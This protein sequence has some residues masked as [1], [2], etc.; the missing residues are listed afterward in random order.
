VATR[1]LRLGDVE[2]PRIGLGTNRL[3]HT[4]DHVELISDAVADGIRHIDTA[5]LYAGGESETTI[6]DALSAGPADIVV[7][8]KGGYHPGDGRP[9]VLRA[10]IDE[11]L[12][13][14]RTDTIALYYLH[15]VDPTTPLEDSFGALK[16]CRDAGKIRHVGISEVS[17]DQVERA[18]R[19]VPITAV[20]NHYSLTERKHE[21]VVDHCA[22]AGIVFVP[23][24]PLRGVSS[25]DLERIAKQHG[26]TSPQIALAWLLRRSPMM[27]PIPGT[28]SRDH[29][30]ENLGALEVELDD[31]E[32]RALA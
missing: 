9:D 28:L 4:P 14:L 2:V 16:E 11:S 21:A 26:A 13:R 32:F 10:Q 22:Q 3:S 29:V 23:Y 19:V 31:E 1:S 20:Q 5:H 30:R 17:V 6:G 18:R 24:F 15:R 25:P 27:L 8:T 7:C 12:R